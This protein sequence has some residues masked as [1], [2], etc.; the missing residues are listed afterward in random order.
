M[1]L[2]CRR[3][4]AD[5]LSQIWYADKVERYFFALLPPITDAQQLSRLLPSDPD[6]R[7]EPPEHLHVTL[8]YLGPVT[9]DRAWFAQTLRTLLASR[10]AIELT[11]TGWDFFPNSRQPKVLALRLRTSAQLAALVRGLDDQ[12]S[13]RFQSRDKPFRPHLSLA[14]VRNDSRPPLPS[15][16]LP[17]LVRFSEVA[18]VGSTLRSDGARYRFLERYAYSQ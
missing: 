13:Q 16:R 11:V 6:W 7:P 3:S 18:V 12:L 4:I 5:S 2:K 17:T 9:I 10:S 8:R 1:I 14:R 15:S